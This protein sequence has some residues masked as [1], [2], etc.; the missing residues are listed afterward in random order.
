M[1]VAA[2][3]TWPPHNDGV[4]LYSAELYAHV[5][6]LVDVKVIAN[7]AE[8]TGFCGDYCGAERIV[9]RSWKRGSFTY[10]LRIFREVLKEKP[11]IVH[12]QH[13]WLLYGNVVASSFILILLFLLRLR[14]IPCVVTMH[15]VIRKGAYLRRS[16]IVNLLARAVIF[17]TSRFIVRFSDRVVVL[18]FLMEK[19]LQEDYGLRGENKIVV[20][21][22]G[23]RGVFGKSMIRGEGGKLW[24]LSLGFVRESKGIE[25]LFKAFEEFVGRCPDANLVVVGGR[26]VHD[27]G[28]Y[29][30]YFKRLVPTNLLR[31]VFFTDFV[32]EERLD[33]LIA[34]S[35]VVVL[36]SLDRFYVE[37]SGALARVAGYGKPVV[38]SRV[39]KFESELQ[40]GK[41]CVM[42]APGDS[43]ELA[44]AF[45]LLALN[46][47]LRESLGE[48]LREKFRGRCWS[49]VAK[50]HFD[51]YREVLET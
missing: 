36:L 10:P 3:T 48:E 33:R 4:A 26:H 16:S 23:V 7:F 21:P 49:A 38:C 27:K 22:H 8:Q 30:D 28:D 9:A 31:H 14:R 5:A 35:D 40:D 1:K 45:M 41:D 51:L 24:V 32:D 37:V 6:E 47:R 29:V 39:L 18:N 20:I 44:R 46:S 17:F 50:Q 25:T 13:G 19:V 11:N 43:E 34:K 15:T 42:V 12:L 2:V